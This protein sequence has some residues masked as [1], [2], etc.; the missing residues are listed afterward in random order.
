MLLDFFL[1]TRCAACG[2]PGRD[3]CHR[4]TAAIGSA[5]AIVIGASGDTPPVAALGAYQGA[6]RNAILSL[7]FRGMR[8]LGRRLGAWLGARL[9]WPFE[10]IVPVPL[11]VDRR[12]E[13]GYNQAAE[14]AR[15][16]A[17]TAS[18]P[19]IEGAIVRARPTAPQSGL[20][21]AG[22]MTNV[23]EAFAAGPQAGEIY[24]RRVLLVDDVVTTGATI[25]ACAKALRT[26]GALNVYVACVAV[27]L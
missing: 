26:S 21:L 23:S 9:I 10:T 22:R 14:I 3:L 8:A 5:E 17:W 25:R 12:R 20:P 18:R 2:I 6:L 15:G 13:R 16:I 24:G 27:R 19:S 11:H 4:C 7:K 1:P